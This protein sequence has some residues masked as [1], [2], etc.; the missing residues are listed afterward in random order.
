MREDRMGRFVEGTD[1]LQR[2]FLPECIEDWVDE[3]NPV[4]VIEAFVEAL[5]LVTLGFDGA[6]P[7]AMPGHRRLLEPVG[8]IPPADVEARYYTMLE[9]P[10]MEG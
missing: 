8:N 6:T 7:A 10:A 5:D 3:D 4:Q 9:D 2:S 1:R